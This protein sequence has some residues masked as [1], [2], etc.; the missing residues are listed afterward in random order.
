[1]QSSRTSILVIRRIQGPEETYHANMGNIAGEQ[2]MLRI[3]PSFQIILDGRKIGTMGPLTRMDGLL[4]L[5][6][7]PPP[8]EKSS[9]FEI[10]AGPH[11]L[12]LSVTK[13]WSYLGPLIT[14]DIQSFEIAP[15]ETVRFLCRYAQAGGTNGIW[16]QFI[17]GPYKHMILL[18]KRVI[19]R[20]LFRNANSST[21]GGCSTSSS[22]SC[23]TAARS[24][25]SS[26]STGECE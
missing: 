5:V 26:S 21:V 19:I 9:L 1:M 25:R 7:P 24:C 11:T 13:Q 23:S 2:E 8:K 10:Q 15:G 20:N 6:L 18:Q 4:R 14:S 3:E 16:Q 17:Q 12:N 22:T